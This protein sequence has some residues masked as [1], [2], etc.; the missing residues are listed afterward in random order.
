MRVLSSFSPGEV[1]FLAFS[2][3][4]HELVVHVQFIDFAV[5]NVPFLHDH[6]P[7]LNV[8]CVVVSDDKCRHENEKDY[9]ISMEDIL[10][11]DWT[12]LSQTLVPIEEVSGFDTAHDHDEEGS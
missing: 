7:I 2:A 10:D 8:R 1:I 5:L 6:I 4:K 9:E 3:F 11:L 12:L